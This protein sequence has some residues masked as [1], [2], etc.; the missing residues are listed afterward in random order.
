MIRINN[1][2]VDKNISDEEVFNIIIKK[3]KMSK[4]EVNK[5][6]ISKKSIDARR[7]DNIHFSYSID[8]DIKSED[9]F[10][11]DKNISKIKEVVFPKIELNM[12]KSIKPIIVG[13][14][15]A[16]LFSA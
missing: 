15:P 3:Y 2:K 14:G 5:W 7:K 16:G 8:I 12:N 4:D 6:Y 9:K 13:A 11:K 1:I 10:L